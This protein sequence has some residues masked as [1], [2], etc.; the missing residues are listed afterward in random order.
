VLEERERL[1]RERE[2]RRKR[3]RAAFLG[4]LEIHRVSLALYFPDLSAVAAFTSVSFDL[5]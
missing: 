4:F 1:R 2:G 5:R 3:E